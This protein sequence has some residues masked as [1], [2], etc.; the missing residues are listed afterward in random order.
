MG[1]CLILYSGY[2]SGNTVYE[3]LQFLL[4]GVE[5]GWRRKN[6]NILSTYLYDELVL[7]QVGQY[8]T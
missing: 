2:K 4:A 1:F 8:F 3:T 6:L 5:V 7:N